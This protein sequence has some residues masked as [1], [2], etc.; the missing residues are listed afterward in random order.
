MDPHSSHN[1]SIP[2]STPLTTHF[3]QP[4]NYSN[5]SNSASQAERENLKTLSNKRIATFAH[6]HRVLEG[7]SHYFNTVTILKEEIY[8]IYD[9]SKLRKRSLQYFTL[10]SS[11]GPIIDI[12]H[13]MD[14]SKALSSLLDE[15]ESYIT[16][17]NSKNKRR[18]NFFRSRTSSDVNNN[19]MNINE[20]SE[21]INLDIKNVPFELDYLQVFY[22]LCNIICVVYHKIVDNMKVP[23]PSS[24][25]E[26]MYKVD[27]KFKKIIQIVTKELDNIVRNSIKEELGIL[28][29]LI[30]QKNNN[31]SYPFEDWEALSM[32][33]K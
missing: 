5:P 2:P 33:S 10:G 9:N 19:S 25:I 4:D 32:D 6:L 31:V 27:N 18:P 14:F 15:Y 1:S 22:A 21:F 28:D 8:S 26:T 23:V 7:K 11:L 17:E 12:H 24:Y 13:P 3:Y 16:N 29:P 30:S 20:N